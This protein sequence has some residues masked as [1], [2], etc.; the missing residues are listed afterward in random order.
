MTEDGTNGVEEEDADDADNDE[1]EVGVVAELL[2]RL[3]SRFCE[4][5]KELP[6]LGA[7]LDC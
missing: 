1:D 4:F 3:L 2:A 7:T 5:I 6:I